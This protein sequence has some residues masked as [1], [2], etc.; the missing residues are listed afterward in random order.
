LKRKEVNS[1]RVPV[2]RDAGFELYDAGT[3]ADAF[4]REAENER[5]PELY[6]YS[7]Y[8]N[9]TVTAAEEEIMQIEEAE[10]ALLTESGMSAVDIALSVFQD[11]R[12]VKPWLF[13]NEI[14]G[15]TISFA[16]SILRKR[17][18]LDINYFSPV[19]GKI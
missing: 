1:Q 15:G 3:A 17:R 4:T 13:F 12:N 7:R 14:Y 9:P 10:W 19:N 5:V 2:Y 16:E 8:R 11:G 6:I 18:G